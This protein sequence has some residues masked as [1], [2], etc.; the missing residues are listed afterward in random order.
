MAGHTGLEPVTYGLTVRRSAIGLMTHRVRGS[1]FFWV[2]HR[3][4]CWLY[5]VYS[6]CYF[7]QNSP[8]A[9]S[10]LKRYD[11]QEPKVS[12]G[13][14]VFR[15]YRLLS[16]QACVQVL[17]FLT[18]YT[19]YTIKFGILQILGS[20]PLFTVDFWPF[21]MSD[22]ALLVDIVKNFVFFLIIVRNDCCTGLIL[23]KGFN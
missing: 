15:A 13:A 5:G 16:F 22:C 17:L 20:R 10:F 4:A 3:R 2:S 11:R 19:N 14:M 12:R 8:L 7:T 23:S 18:F 9:R 6:L 21:L 1:G